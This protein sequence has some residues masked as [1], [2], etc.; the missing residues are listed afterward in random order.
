MKSVLVYCEVENQKV[1]DISQE[2]L[3]AGKRLA[4]KLDCP[5]KAMIFGGN[6]KNIES[7]IAPFG[8]DT[9]FVGDDTK[10]EPYRTLPHV[11]L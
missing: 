1:A 4:Q 2:L 8:V 9:L 7:Q 5:L 3:S 6:L 10:L 11:A